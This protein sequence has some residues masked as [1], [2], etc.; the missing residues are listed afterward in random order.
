MNSLIPVDKLFLTAKELGQSAIAITDNGTLAAAWD[1][2]QASKKTGVKLIIGCQFNFVDDVKNENAQIRHIILTARNHEGYKNLLLASKLGYDNSVL[3]AKKVVPR[4]DWS[5]LKRCSAG[6]ICTTAGG[7]GILGKLI[8]N[9]KSDEAFNQAKRLKDIF[10]D[11]LAFEIQP[12]AMTRTVTSYNDYEDQTFLNNKLIKFGQDLDVKVIAATNAHYLTKDK[13]D[14][15]DVL[16]AI[17]QGLPYKMKTRLRYPVPEFY[18]KS[19]DEVVKFFER[20]YGKKA[21]EFC[22][23]T[24]YFSEL[25]EKPEWID[26]KFSNPSGKELPVFPVKDQKD[27]HEFNSWVTIQPIEIQNKPEDAKYLRYLCD[28]AFLKKAI[29]SFKI[30]EY[31]DRVEK[32]IDVFECQDACSYMLIVYDYISKAKEMGIPVGPGRGSFG[33]SIVGY[34]LNMHDADSIKYGLI[35]ERFY[36]KSRSTLSDIDADFSQKGKA[37][38]EDYIINKYGQ[39]YC[40]K[41]SNFSTLTPKPFIKSIAR[42][43]LFGGDHKE[44]VKIGM[45]VADSV[46]KEIDTIDDAIAKIPLFAEFANSKQ[47]NELS[48]YKEL[49]NIFYNFATHAAAIIISKRP[50]HSIVPIRKTKD[51][52]YSLEYEKDRAEA[53]GL[54]KMDILG[55]STLDIIESTFN[56]IKLRNKTPPSLPWNYDL[57]DEKTYELM[58]THDLHGIFQFGG[59]PGTIDLCVKMKPKNIEDLAMITSMCRPGFPKDIREQFIKDKHNNNKAAVKFPILEK[60]LAPTFGYA[61]FDE[62][63]LQLAHDVAG[64]NLDEADRLRKFVKDK[65]NNP[66]KNKKL[67]QDF[68]ESSIKNGLEPE[69]ANRIWDEV[70]LNFGAYI[71]NKS[72]AISYSMISYQTAYLK[73]HFPLEFLIANLIHQDESNAQN[74]D[75]NITQ[76]KKEIRE[77]RVKILP[78]DINKSGHVYKIIDENSVFTGFNS[79]K[80]IGSDSIPEI[81]EKRPFSSFEEFMRKVDASKV[82]VPA[83]QALA[84][85]GCLDSFGLTRKQMVL[86]ASDYRKKL[87]A[88][89]KRKGDEEFV[90]PWP[91][92]VGEWTLAEKYAQEVFYLGEGFCC[93]PHV[94]YPNFFDKNALDFSKIAQFFPDPGNNEKYP[95]LPRQGQVQGIVKDVFELRVKKEDSKIYGQTLTKITLEDIYGNIIGMTVFPSSLDQFND[96]LRLLSRGKIA[97]EPGIAI[98]CAA[99]ATWYN[100]NVGLIFEDLKK[101]HPIPPRPNDLKHKKVSMRIV[102]KK[103]TKSKKIDPNKFLEEIED[104][105]AEE[106]FS[107]LNE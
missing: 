62:V 72:H 106:G 60:S 77:L 22:D 23:N 41:V 55:L 102:A 24:L 82:K 92:N 36:S 2:L 73:A 104:E 39:D 87:Q 100:D 105:L 3:G 58:G 53:N 68:I 74:S 64:W 1:G 98:S 93:Q 59:S 71:F 81:L 76:I 32:E 85:S 103:K 21:E 34:L 10:G 49:N 95:I 18:V 52:Q 83:I 69:I 107:D 38:I 16:L 35:F 13:A 66:E 5:I 42:T 57:N 30:K 6:V 11:Y 44:A 25:C 91:N 15:H 86:Y 45:Q 94:A 48:K 79:L 99:A 88:W 31:K 84:S 19:R 20:R 78:P 56:I 51:G 70:V 12:H 80:F 65:G 67:Q 33:A 46:P 40:A 17:G 97:L 9:K 43:F 61:L 8:N 37:L 54:V 27:Y 50:I 63:L 28:L 96:R 101:I 89:V 90:Y 4:I 75:G 29:D 26:P 14:V 47:Y 7:G